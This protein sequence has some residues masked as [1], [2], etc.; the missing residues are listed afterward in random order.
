MNDLLNAVLDTLIPAS[1]DGRMPGA[2]SL[3]LADAVHAQTAQAKDLIAGGLAAAE[4]AGFADLDLE[5]RVA[6]LRDLESS[7]PGFVPTLYLTVL[8][9]Y[10]QQP[11]VL[12]GLGL[13]PRPPHPKGYDL[14]PGNLDALER[15]RARGKLWRDA[16]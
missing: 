15:V 2:G 13:E 7:K 9:M 1:A 3:G 10:Y 12:V 16:G 11:K 14:E 5:D 4:S 8:P 6:L